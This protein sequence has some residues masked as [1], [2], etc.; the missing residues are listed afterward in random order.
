MDCDSGYKPSEIRA[1]I[2]ILDSYFTSPNK[3]TLS[4]EQIFLTNFQ[5]ELQE[6]A[7]ADAIEMYRENLRKIGAD[8]IIG[9]DFKQ[10][11]D[12]FCDLFSY[13]FFSDNR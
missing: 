6:S 9:K 10:Y 1:L 8:R 4:L 12:I 13:E 7:S 11:S 5:L 3:G 2:Q